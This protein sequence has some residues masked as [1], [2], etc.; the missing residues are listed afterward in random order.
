MMNEQTTGC[1][2]YLCQ[3]PSNLF[4]EKFI[5][6]KESQ[7]G[8]QLLHSIFECFCQFVF[9]QDFTRFKILNIVLF[10]ILQQ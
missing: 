9:I 7:T 8:K 5:G 2:Y 1:H 10:N 6:L 4:L 3:K